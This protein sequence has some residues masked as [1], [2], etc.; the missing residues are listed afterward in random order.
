MD[1]PNFDFEALM[2]KEDE[3]KELRP[4]S[5]KASLKQEGFFPDPSKK[6]R[7]AKMVDKI[8]DYFE[9]GNFKALMQF[10]F[11]KHKTLELWKTIDEKVEIHDWLDFFEESVIKSL[12]RMTN[13]P[14]E[15]DIEIGE[16]FVK[17]QVKTIRVAVSAF[18]VNA[19][20]E[21]AAKMREPWHFHF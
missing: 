18:D 12:R 15:V 19:F 13:I 9:D 5:L 17:L 21:K 3:M 7:F 11:E 10:L 4:K 8:V 20:A 14:E 1:I 16:I 6:D 2:E